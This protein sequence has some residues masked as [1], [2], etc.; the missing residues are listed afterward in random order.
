MVILVV[1]DSTVLPAFRTLASDSLIRSDVEIDRVT[2]SLLSIM[3][4][5]TMEIF[6][7]VHI[8]FLDV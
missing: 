7:T 1:I 8:H 3:A 2:L 4:G 6:N 5:I